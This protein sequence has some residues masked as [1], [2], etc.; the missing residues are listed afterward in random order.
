MSAAQAVLPIHLVQ[1]AVLPLGAPTERATALPAAFREAERED[2]V[3]TRNGIEVGVWEGTAGRF[4]ARRDG[5]TEICQ[6]LSGHAILHTD[7]G[8]DVELNVGDTI[9]MPT[10]W[11]GSW[12]MLEPTRKL[13]IIVHD[14]G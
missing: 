2:H 12:E 1:P 7:G 10:G 14:R 11:T 4:P 5:Y 9:V 6:I 13:Y 8:G 3:D